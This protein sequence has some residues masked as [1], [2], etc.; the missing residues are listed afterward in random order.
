MAVLLY[1][2]PQ[3]CENGVYLRGIFIPWH[4]IYRAV[5]SLRYKGVLMIYY[6]EGFRKKYPYLIYV[7]EVKKDEA[8]KLIKEK[9]PEAWKRSVVFWQ[10]L[11]T[12]T[13][14]QAHARHHS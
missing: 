6:Q 13:R 2:T 4:R 7:G 14:Q 5:W 8:I 9:C 3:F 11:I 10:S 1:V 12:A